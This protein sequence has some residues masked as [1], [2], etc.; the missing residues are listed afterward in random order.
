MNNRKNKRLQISATIS[1]ELLP[2]DLEIPIIDPS[3]SF[4]IE[5]DESSLATLITEINPITRNNIGFIIFVI[6]SCVTLGLGYLFFYWF[7][8]TKIKLIYKG[9]SI[10]TATKLAILD[11]NGDIDIVT[12]E[13]K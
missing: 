1:E 6:V 11:D 8:K 12:L 10:E 7:P 4:K 13:K 2:S 5:Q 3:T 9:C